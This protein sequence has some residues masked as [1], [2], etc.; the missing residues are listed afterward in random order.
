[1]TKVLEPADEI[2]EKVEKEELQPAIAR[3]AIKGLLLVMIEEYEKEI[4]SK[5]ER[6]SGLKKALK[7]AES[8]KVVK[9]TEKKPY[10]YKE[11]ECIYCGKKF[12][13]RYGAHTICDECK[14]KVM[15][16]KRT[17]AALADM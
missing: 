8:S 14:D 2:F 15:D 10:V 12:T 1:M 4:K 6:I 5:D 17:A 9:Q 3:M 16:V 11:K 13:P 7:L